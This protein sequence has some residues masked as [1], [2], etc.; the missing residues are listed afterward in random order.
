MVW[1]KKE[2]MAFKILDSFSVNVL[3][4]SLVIPLTFI[5]GRIMIQFNSTN[6][7]SGHFVLDPFAGAGNTLFAIILP[8]ES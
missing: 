7:D 4:W 8:E 2:T 1:I 3:M 6:G 5:A